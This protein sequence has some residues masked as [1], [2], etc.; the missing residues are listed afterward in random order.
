MYRAKEKIIMNGLM[1]IIIKF[2]INIIYFGE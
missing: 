2:G 1:V